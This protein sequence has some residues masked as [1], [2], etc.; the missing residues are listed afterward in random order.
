MGAGLVAPPAGVALLWSAYLGLVVLVVRIWERPV[1]VACAG[2][3]AVV[4]WV[5]VVGL[6]SL[7]F[8]WTA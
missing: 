7:L 8:G 5:S 6:G 4:V 3:A 2:P 1:L